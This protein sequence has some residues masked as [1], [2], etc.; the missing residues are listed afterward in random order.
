ME[1]EQGSR[2]KLA[3]DEVELPSITSPSVEAPADL[4]WINSGFV[5]Y[6]QRLAHPINH[7]RI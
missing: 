6:M 3:A 2:A 5:R 7:V 1:E 4:V